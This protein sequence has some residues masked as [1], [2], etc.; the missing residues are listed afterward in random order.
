MSTE[1]PFCQAVEGTQIG[2]S[3]KLSFALQI[4]WELGNNGF[5]SVLCRVMLIFCENTSCSSYF[6]FSL[7]VKGV[8]FL[9]TQLNGVVLFPYLHQK[10]HF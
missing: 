3:Q 5:Y 10:L 7:M 2:K 1:V 8:S 6:R 4:L 9:A